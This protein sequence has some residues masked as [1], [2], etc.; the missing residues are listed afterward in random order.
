MCGAD[1][2]LQFGVVVPTVGPRGVENQL[3]ALVEKAV[4]VVVLH[5]DGNLTQVVGPAVA[6][7]LA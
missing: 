6:V 7:A 3:V 2:A 4:P 5:L 1:V